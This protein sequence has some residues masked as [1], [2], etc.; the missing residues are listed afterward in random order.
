MKIS[1]VVKKGHA[2]AVDVN[3]RRHA[4]A[5]ANAIAKLEGAPPPDEAFL[6]L[7]EQVIMGLLTF[8]EAVKALISAAL[9]K[10]DAT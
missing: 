9:N 3:A 4:F 7:Q 8:D 6:R 1:D 5:T 2:S 10:P